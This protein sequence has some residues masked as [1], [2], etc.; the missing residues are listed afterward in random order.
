MY[1]SPL[2]FSNIEDRRFVVFVPVEGNIWET[3]LRNK[4]RAK[5]ISREVPIVGQVSNKTADDVAAQPCLSSALESQ[6]EIRNV[7]ENH[8]VVLGL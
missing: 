1:G 6:P 8:A 3:S 5:P 4:N 7:T 2:K